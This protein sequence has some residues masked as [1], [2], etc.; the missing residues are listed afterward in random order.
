MAPHSLYTDFPKIHQLR[1]SESR[2]SIITSENNNPQ[3]VIIVRDIPSV[4]SRSKNVPRAESPGQRLAA[5][6]SPWART[7]TFRVHPGVMST[8]RRALSETTLWAGFVQHPGSL[9]TDLEPG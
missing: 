8:I 9:R 6:E 2:P 1:A 5:R 3:V 7:A 4:P